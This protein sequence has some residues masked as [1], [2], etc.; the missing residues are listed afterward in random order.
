MR[1]FVVDS[2]TCLKWVFEDEEDAIIA[3][4][5]LLDYLSGN[6]ML[7][8]PNLWVYEVANGIRSAVLSKRIS[9]EKSHQLLDLVLKAK[10]ALFPM[11][12]IMGGCL[13]NSNKYQISIYDSSYLT[14]AKQHRVKFITRDEKLVKKLEDL[15]ITVLLKDYEYEP[16]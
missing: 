14:L 9:E 16:S 12:Q 6:V 10:P 15:D 2:S 11:E 4:K 1:T 7:V 8:A 3:K 13:I 5:I